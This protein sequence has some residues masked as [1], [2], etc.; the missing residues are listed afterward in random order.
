[1]LIHH[2]KNAFF[3]ALK[4]YMT[5]HAIYRQKAR[6]KSKDICGSER[7]TAVCVCQRVNLTLNDRTMLWNHHISYHNATCVFLFYTVNAH[8]TVYWY[9][10]HVHILTTW[11][12]LIPPHAEISIFIGPKLSCPTFSLKYTHVSKYCI[13]CNILHC[14]KSQEHQH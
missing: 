11:G 9:S 3:P 5:C 4:R 2:S 13:P 12:N 1:M 7:L 10:K 14:G 6:T 8:N